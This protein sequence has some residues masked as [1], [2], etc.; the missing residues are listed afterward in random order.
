MLFNID[1]ESQDPYN[2]TL[3]LSYTKRPG[4]DDRWIER[5]LPPGEH[6]IELS[7]KAPNLDVTFLGFEV[8]LNATIPT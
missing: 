7:S 3:L 1:P 8:Q 4:G 2:T 5:D 6:V